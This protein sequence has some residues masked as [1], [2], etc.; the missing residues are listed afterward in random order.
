MEKCLDGISSR[1]D[2]AK[3]VKIWKNHKI[4]G[5]RNEQN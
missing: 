5:E 2:A 1:E 4:K 3:G